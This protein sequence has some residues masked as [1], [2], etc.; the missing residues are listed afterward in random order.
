[1]TTSLAGIG[2]PVWIGVGSILLGIV[3]AVVLR[4]R[5][6]TPYWRRKPELADPAVLDD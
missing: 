3:I 5:A 6:R 2:T 4:L 1:V